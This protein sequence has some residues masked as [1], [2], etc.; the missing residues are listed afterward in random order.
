MILGFKPQFQQMVREGSKT[1]T[2]RAPRRDG[3]V[4]KVGETLHCY[5]GLRQKKGPTT[6][7]GRWKCKK[8]EPI[9]INSVFVRRTEAQPALG[10]KS[11]EIRTLVILIDGRELD[12]SETELLAY[13][14]G[15]RHKELGLAEGGTC[16]SLME[17]FWRQEHKLGTPLV[18]CFH[19]FIYH[20]TW[21]PEGQR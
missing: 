1:H 10:I 13:R 2:I 16:L 20:W 11:E 19:G 15:F 4:P 7:L 21:T 5:V 17:R 12:P 9:E 14:D 6:L 3:I 18:K 8:V